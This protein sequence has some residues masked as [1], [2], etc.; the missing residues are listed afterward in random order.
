VWPWPYVWI[1]HLAMAIMLA[2]CGLGCV[3]QRAGRGHHACYVLALAFPC[4][5]EWWSY[6]IPSLSKSASVHVSN[7]LGA[8]DA[9]IARRAGRVSIV[10]GMLAEVVGGLFMLA[11]WRL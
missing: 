6:R 5:L 1:S 8:G 11:A 4:Y 9:F 10:R 3:D 2:A 7:K